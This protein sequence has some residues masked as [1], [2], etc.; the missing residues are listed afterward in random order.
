MTEKFGGQP[1]VWK[2]EETIAPA[3]QDIKP[4]TDPAFD[5]LSI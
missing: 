4:G 2:P 1:F 5:T 3:V